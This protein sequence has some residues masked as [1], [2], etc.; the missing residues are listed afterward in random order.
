ML[1]FQHL[2]KSA[3]TSK[4]LTFRNFRAFS[5]QQVI[6]YILSDVSSTQKLHT[7][8]RL[9]Q[10][11]SSE[12]KIRKLSELDFSLLFFS[13]LSPRQLS[14]SLY[15]F[16]TNIKPRTWTLRVLRKSLRLLFPSFFFDNTTRLY[17]PAVFFYIMHIP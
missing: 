15:L 16:N 17:T 8:T 10:H 3:E 2:R 4:I 7:I 1:Q 11:E 12:S 9:C 5:Y 13:V 14:L 6:F